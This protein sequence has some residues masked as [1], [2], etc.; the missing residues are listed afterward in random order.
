MRITVL[1]K[2]PSW[3]DAGGACSGYLVTAGGFNLLLDCGSGVFAKLRARIDYL[4]L[5]A[6][7]ITHLH[8]DHFFDLVPFSYGLTYTPRGG[9]ARPALYVPPGAQAVFRE[10]LGAWGEAELIERAFALSEYDPARTLELGPLRARFCEVPHFTRTFAVELR[11]GAKR[12]TFGADCGP[13]EE[14]VG[15]ARDTDLVM[16]EATLSEP[17]GADQGHLSAREAGEHARLAR[18]RRLVL[19]H[20]SDEL[21]AEHIRAEA[22]EGFGAAVELAAE[23]AAYDV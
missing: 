9:G 20:F 18:A 2:S 8:S 16:L 1:G 4:S 19:T 13:N 3:A 7:L 10:T 6:V 21:D 23:G 15:F 22:G 5:D 17:E 14:L 12:F 11:E